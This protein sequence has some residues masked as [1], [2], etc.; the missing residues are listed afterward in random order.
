MAL[1]GSTVT[2]LRGWCL[3]MVV[4]AVFPPAPSMN[5]KKRGEG[6]SLPA[7]VRS[8]LEWLEV[9]RNCTPNTLRAYRA[10]LRQ[11]AGWL[12]DQRMVHD[13]AIA[14]LEMLRG[15]LASLGSIKIATRIH[16]QTVLRGFYGWLHAR[17]AIA[18]NPAAL[19][20]R[21]RRPKQLPRYL[22]VAEIERMLD[23]TRGDDPRSRRG[24]ALL[25]L[26]Y[27]SGMRA[28]EA[29]TLLASR[30]ELEHGLCWVMGKGRRERM[31]LVGKPARLALR[32]WLDARSRF[33]GMMRWRD[34]GTVFINFRDGG[35]MSSRSIGRVVKDIGRAADITQRV[36]P[37]LLRHSCATHLVD[38]G[39]DIRYVQELLGHASLS[40]T[41]IYTHVSS[42]RLR[43]VIAAA[44]PRG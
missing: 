39:V 32:H 42:T 44:H 17:G 9:G 34:P 37:H 14:D 8:Y 27:S 38:R 13:P 35:S 30:V 31:C 43:D 21:A 33:L 7:V 11:F 36:H 40:T 1:R 20:Q 2:I 26:L 5:T 18:A 16:K 15:F 19:M 29:S 10:D 25:E 22:S 24:L 28:S 4:T 3:D 23:A 6:P 41:A 12:R